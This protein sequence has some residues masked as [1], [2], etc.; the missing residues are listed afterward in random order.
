MH[1]QSTYRTVAELMQNLRTH[2]TRKSFLAMA[3]KESMPRI[4][5]NKRVILFDWAEVEK[6]LRRRARG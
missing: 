6:W 1:T 4:E 2:T 3:R 5:V